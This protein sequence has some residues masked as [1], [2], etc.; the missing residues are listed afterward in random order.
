MNMKR[1]M[2][3]IFGMGLLVVVLAGMTGCG[4]EESDKAGF[5]VY[6]SVYP[7]YDLTV[8]L[9]GDVAEVENLVP[10]GV[11]PHDFEMGTQDMVKLTEADLLVYCGA[12]MENWVEQSLKTLGKE[13]PKSVMASEGVTLLSE[14]DTEDPHI[15]LDPKNAVIMLENIKKA[16]CEADPQHEEIYVSN[17]EKYKEKLL[18][19][20]DAYKT[21][22][23]QVSRHDIVVSHASFGYLCAA[24]GLNQTAIEGLMAD[25]E[26]DPATMTK[27]ISFMKEQNIQFIFDE[28]LVNNKVVDTI[29]KETGAT[30]EILDPVEGLS[31]ERIDAGEEYFSIMEK[32]LELLKQALK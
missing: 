8:K 29:A 28:E 15:W 30:V 20:D 4:K 31:Q 5:T 18:Q 12:G 11:E 3:R 6:T 14:E 22:M 25:S 1:W 23:A 16:L 13:A 9:A 17:Y 2:K 19:L 26:P 7:V 27:I 21:A 10:A 24:Y 32:N